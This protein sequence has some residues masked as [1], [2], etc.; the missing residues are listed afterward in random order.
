MSS[1]EQTAQTARQSESVHFPHYV[2]NWILLPLVSPLSLNEIF[3]Q[4]VFC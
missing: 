3:I 4:A 1:Y 2:F